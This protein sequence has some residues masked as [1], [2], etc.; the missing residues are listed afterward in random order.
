LKNCEV[1]G[2][3]PLPLGDMPGVV[4]DDALL[5]FGGASGMDNRAEILRVDHAGKT[6]D[7][8]RLPSPSRG[9]QAVKM[10]RHVYILGGFAEGTLT[11]AYRLD[12]TNFK[13]QSIAPMPRDNAWFTATPLGDKIYVM[14]GFSIPNGYWKEIAIYD[15]KADA[16]TLQKSFPHHLFPKKS[17]GS[18]A[19]LS[20]GGR[21]LST[22]GADT[23]D[24]ETMRANALGACAMFDP[25]TGEWE[26]LPFE[27]E[28]REGLVA[29]RHGERVF[30]VGGMLNPPAHASDLI[31]V[32]DSKGM[33]TAPFARLQQGRAAAACGVLNDRLIVAGGVTEGIAEMTDTIE[34]VSVR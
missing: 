13:A 8:G 27:I 34:A 28:P 16:W 9:H 7:V 29:V 20:L 19:A 24:G 30:I 12:L 1:I 18:N 33:S 3:L 15:V 6:T 17:L 32:V 2:R 31:D 26:R 14:G 21:I 23:F 5:V 11:D 25:S 10:D 4:H 22:G